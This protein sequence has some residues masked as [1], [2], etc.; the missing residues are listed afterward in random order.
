MRAHALSPQRAAPRWRGLRRADP[1]A[2]VFLRG[3]DADAGLRE[4]A[5]DAANALRE[6]QLVSRRFKR[7]DVAPRALVR[8]AR[9][10]FEKLRDYRGARQDLLDL[11]NLWPEYGKSAEVNLILGRTCLE[12]GLLDR[13]LQVFGRLYHLN[14]TADSQRKACLGAGESLYRKGD[15]QEAARWLTRYVKLTGRSGR[16]DLARAYLLLGRSE[17]ALGQA[18]RAAA[19][20]QN[21]VAWYST[22]RQRAAAALGLAEAHLDRKDHLSAVGVLDSMDSKRLRPKE[23][24]EYLLLMARTYREMGLGA[25]AQMILAEGNKLAVIDDPEV[26]GAI[27]VELA[28]CYAET[29][30]L[31]EARKWL[32]E[33]VARLKPGKLASEAGLQLADV[34]LKLR[35]AEQAVAVAREL[36]GARN[37]AGVRQRATEILVAAYAMQQN[38]EAAADALSAVAKDKGALR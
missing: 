34:C 27:L 37:P 11:L 17:A 12:A 7:D 22:D 10:R 29:G 9:I 35:N 14:L 15:F 20:F 16:E 25:R 28:R 36:A 31:A 6:Y 24:Q 3:C 4:L 8:C 32:L 21:A 5:G 13:A 33:A 18:D 38:Y 19:A 1:G 26:R 30:N 23:L 2:L